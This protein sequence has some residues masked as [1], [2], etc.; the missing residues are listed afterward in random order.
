[1]RMPRGWVGGSTNRP[2]STGLVRAGCDTSVRCNDGKTGRDLAQKQGHT[3]VL[4][5]LAAL[6]RTEANRK[7]KEQKR[8]KK[9]EQKRLERELQMLRRRLVRE[10]TQDLLLK[11]R[12]I[13]GARVVIAQVSESDPKVLRELVDT[14]KGKL[15]SGIVVLAADADGKAALAAGVTKDLTDRFHAGEIIKEAARVVGGKGGGRPDMAQDASGLGLYQRPFAANTGYG[16]MQMPH[17]SGVARPEDQTVAHAAGPCICAPLLRRPD[18]LGLA[19]R[20]RL[21]ASPNRLSAG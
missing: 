13:G 18:R 2:R 16:L 19:K 1:M 12:D 20:F 5:R 9:E 15:K 11:A 17:L 7:K 4:E 6:K 10:E 3:A 8:R 21:K 14:F